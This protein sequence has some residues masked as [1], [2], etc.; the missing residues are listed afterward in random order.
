ME[1]LWDTLTKVRLPG[2]SDPK[3][4]VPRIHGHY[5]RG[6]DVPP[7]QGYRQ[8]RL[9]ASHEGQLDYLA[10]CPGICAEVP[11]RAYVGAFLQHYSLRHWNLY[12]RSYQEEE[13][14]CFEEEGKF[15]TRQV[16]EV[17]LTQESIMAIVRATREGKTT[18]RVATIE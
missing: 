7:G 5:C 17:K 13:A 2:V 8:G 12:Q 16:R 18:F 6:K 1:M 4:R 15:I 11:A 9:H 10:T 3:F 14:G